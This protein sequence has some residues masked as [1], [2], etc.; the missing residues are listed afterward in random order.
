MARYGT[1]EYKISARIARKE[2]A[3]FVRED[4]EDLGGYDQ[5]GRILRGLMQKGKL[6]RIGYGLYAK[7]R[8]S[9]LTGKTVPVQPLP[10]LAKEALERLGLT[11]S[12]SRLEQEYNA[13]KTTQVP[14][15]RTI[16]V[17]GRVSRKIGYNGAYISYEAAP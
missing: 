6:V 2:N 14:T 3:V 4:F 11:I 16:A 8:V 5:I 9:T 10:T 13:G 1:L 15:G 12:P 17:K 7:A